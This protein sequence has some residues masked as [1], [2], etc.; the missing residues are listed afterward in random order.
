MFGAILEFIA[1]L[2]RAWQVPNSVFSFRI[3]GVSS[4]EALIFYAPMTL[5]ILVL[6]EHFFDKD[7]N[8]RLSPNI[9]YAVL[10]GLLTYATILMI[11]FSNPSGLIF[12]HSYLKM[13]LAAIAPLAL[14]I[15]LKPRLIP[16]YCKLALLIFPIFFITELIGIK[17]NYWLFPGSEYL[18]KVTFLGQTFPVEEIIFWMLLYP[19]AIA[20]YYEEFIDDNK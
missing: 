6:Y 10:P 15:I 17:F 2:N 11:Y 14:Q 18:G 20:C 12:S 1:H 9:L 13:G 3:F 8:H 19:A 5:F 16:K 4:F 7:I